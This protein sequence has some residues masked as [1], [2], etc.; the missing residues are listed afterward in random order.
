MRKL[1]LF[2]FICL[3]L[4]GFGQIGLGFYD[5]PYWGDTYYRHT[6]PVVSSVQI[7]QSVYDSTGFSQY[8]DLT[9]F[10]T[11]SLADTAQYLWVEGTPAAFDFPDANMVDYNPEASNGAYQYFIKNETGFYFSGQSGGFETEQGIF[12]IK[13]EFRP[14]VPVVKVPAKFGDV[15]SETS[16]AAVDLFT[17]GNVKLTTKTDYWIN[18]FG[19]VKTPVGEEFE[20]L[21]IKRRTKSEVIFS[22]QLGEN[23]IEDTTINEETSWEFFASGYGDPI[24]S[25]TKT[26]DEI[27]GL[28]QYSMFYKDK[29]IKSSLNEISV[30][31]NMSLIHLS[32]YN[33][34]IIN[35]PDLKNGG[36]IE[37][38]N[39]NGQLISSLKACSQ[40][41]TIET[42]Y[43]AKG[44]YFVKT[45]GQKGQIETKTISIN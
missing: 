18:G 9:V 28:D 2:L 3:S 13:A 16:R 31:N 8:W 22:I 32:N 44:V 7:P 12:D 42:S 30:V 6:V 20:V 15:V 40:S 23:K 35:D 45:E 21:R 39:L 14:A 5:L 10:G 29:R 37:V 24:A 17:I 36:L 1:S 34:L 4:Q 11:E 38:Y 25:I 41:N 26:K 33:R 27:V 43:F 19:T